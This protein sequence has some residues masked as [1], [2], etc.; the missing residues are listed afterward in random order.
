MSVAAPLKIWNNTR[1]E[2]NL[3]RHQQ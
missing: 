2:M 3:E 1:I